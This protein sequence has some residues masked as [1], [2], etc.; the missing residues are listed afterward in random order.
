MRVLIKKVLQLEWKMHVANEQH[1][2]SVIEW[3][4]LNI[5]IQLI[6]K[7]I[8]VET[9]A[10][11][12]NLIFTKNLSECTLVGVGQPAQWLDCQNYIIHRKAMNHLTDV[13]AV[14]HSAT[15]F[16]EVVGKCKKCQ[17]TSW[18]SQKISKF[19]NSCQILQ[20]FVIVHFCNAA[21]M[22]FAVSFEAVI[23]GPH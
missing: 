11:K 3:A 16:D 15:L 17:N 22:H 8:I 12:W 23:L 4:N 21:N 18:N 2:A 13:D 6:Y 1:F 19:C 7:N 9:V 14:L 10:K 5:S 20:H